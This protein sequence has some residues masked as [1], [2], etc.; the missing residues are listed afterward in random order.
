MR[1]LFN[2][3]HPVRVLSPAAAVTDNTAQV[4]QIVDRKGYES[5]TYLINA[6]GLADADV[7]VTALLEHGDDIGGG[8]MTAVPDDLLLGTEAGASLTFADDNEL[9][10]LGYVG[11]KR[12]TRLTLTP[13]NNAGNL[14]VSAVAVLAHPAMSPTPT[15]S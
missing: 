12:Y 11:H 14:F 5:V 8:D 7:T 3:I 15:L 4:G 9:R 1:D 10:K 2:T 6:G 13:A